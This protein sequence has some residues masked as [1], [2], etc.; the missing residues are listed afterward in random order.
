MPTHD[1]SIRNAKQLGT[2][3][4]AVRKAQSLRQ[5]EVGRISHSFI[6]DL[7][8]GKPTVQLG[9]VL[10]A[11]N[12]LGVQLRLELPAGLD[13][14]HFDRYLRETSTSPDESR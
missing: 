9:K 1:I 7:E 2:V 4:R 12:E 11:L 10:E 8:D 6:G 13:R 14:A 3:V 5:D